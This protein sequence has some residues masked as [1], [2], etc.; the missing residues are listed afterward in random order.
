MGATVSH[1]TSSAVKP[2][3]TLLPKEHQKVCPGQTVA[4][5]CFG[6]GSTMELFSPPILSEAEAFKFHSKN[7]SLS[8]GPTCD[9]RTDAAAILN[10]VETWNAFSLTGILTLNIPSDLRRG[11][12]SVYCRVSTTQGDVTTMS[13]TFLVLDGKD[14]FQ[15]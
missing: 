12:Y 11:M 9:V 3:V 10:L 4:Y 8:E 1:L 13:S 6:D 14:I 15:T 2:S 7:K 5:N